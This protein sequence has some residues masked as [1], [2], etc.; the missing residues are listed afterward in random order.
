MTE[1]CT[2]SYATRRRPAGLSPLCQYQCSCGSHGTWT[3]RDT[4]TEQGK[5]HGGRES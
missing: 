5:R 2:V 3:D 1:E 4:A